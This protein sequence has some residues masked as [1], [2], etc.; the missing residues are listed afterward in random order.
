M[1]QRLAQFCVA[2]LNL[3]E[4]PHVLDG[5]HGLGGKGFE[6]LDLFIGK[7][8]DLAPANMYSSD[9]NSVMDQWRNEYRAHALMLCPVL[10]K[11]GSRLRG[12]KVMDV[13]RLPV[14]HGAADGRGAIDRTLS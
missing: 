14:D 8:S 9:R 6:K 5:D 11:R 4:Q 12:L 3:F 2:L 1:L 10:R 13:N 7:G